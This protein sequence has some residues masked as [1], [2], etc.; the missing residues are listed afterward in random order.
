MRSRRSRVFFTVFLSLFAAGLAGIGLHA[1]F[2]AGSL[3][4]QQ[5]ARLRQD[6]LDSYQE[7]CTLTTAAVRTAVTFHTEALVAAL[8]EQGGVLAQTQEFL[9]LRDENNRGTPYLALLPGLT[10]AQRST[11][12]SLATQADGSYP[13]GSVVY[14]DPRSKHPDS[15]TV[16][17]TIFLSLQP[18]GR[19][20]EWD[21]LLAAPDDRGEA[22]QS[23]LP[24]LR[25]NTAL[26]DLARLVELVQGDAPAMSLLRYEH[27]VSQSPA[28][29]YVQADVL[30]GYYVTCPL[31]DWLSLMWR[32][33][34][35]WLGALA[36]GSAAAALL[37]ARTPKNRT[38]PGQ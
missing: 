14:P 18:T 15:Q 4:E 20:G 8:D 7:C 2:Q 29:R 28:P 16:G 23:W 26:P 9:L 5:T 11:L 13:Y 6:M 35:I 32:R 22:W 30:A 1:A 10:D 31:T 38:K 24:Y 37:A 17:Q 19:D 3:A 36:L 25:Q 12:R 27:F 21:M 34:L 33:C